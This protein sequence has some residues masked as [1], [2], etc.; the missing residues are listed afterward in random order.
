MKYPLPV[1]FRDNLGAAQA[2]ADALEEKVAELE[3]ENER[4][5]SYD[6]V[7]EAASEPER[8]SK[9]AILLKVLAVCAV[10]V[11]ISALIGGMVFL[12]GT[13]TA[14]ALF[15]VTAVTMRLVVVAA[16]QELLVISGR[17]HRSPSGELC[18]YRVVKHGTVVPLPLIERVDRMSTRPFPISIRVENAYA[19]KATGAD[20]SGEAVIRIHDTPPH[21]ANAV[22]RFLGHG[23]K[24]IATVA[25]ETLEG[26]MRGVVATMTLEELQADLEKL[27]ALMIEEAEPDLDKLG[28]NLVR[29]ELVEV[30]ES[31]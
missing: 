19:A 17:K 21:S 18:H 13:A 8:A 22:E 15:V 11:V 12:V 20:V 7:P 31:G 2:R 29:L 27:S 4:L 30:T 3:A 1:A 14:C 24:E 25:T 16:P 9:T 23:R 5:R 10:M 26:M 6:L 28:I